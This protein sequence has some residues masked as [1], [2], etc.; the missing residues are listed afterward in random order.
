MVTCAS[1]LDSK[2][3]A[4]DEPLREAWRLLLAVAGSKLLHCEQRLVWRMHQLS[5]PRVWAL[6]P[7]PPLLLS[8]LHER[9]LPASSLAAALLAIA[10]A[11]RDSRS[12]VLRADKYEYLSEFLRVFRTMGVP[13]W[14]ENYIRVMASLASIGLL[15]L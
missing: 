13:L 14:P 7:P 1:V 4:A 3:R 8:H 15:A 9:C 11:A 5:E 12:P 10:A 2:Q 6:L